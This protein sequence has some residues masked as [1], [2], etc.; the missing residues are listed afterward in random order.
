MLLLMSMAQLLG[1]ACSRKRNV[2][3]YGPCGFI[4]GQQLEQNLGRRFLHLSMISP[5]EAIK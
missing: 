4:I 1:N 5:L 2:N 3:I